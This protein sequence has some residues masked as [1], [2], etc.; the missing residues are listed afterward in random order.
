MHAMRDARNKTTASQVKLLGSECQASGIYAKRAMKITTKDNAAAC[1]CS[2]NCLAFLRPEDDRAVSILPWV[3]SRGRSHEFLWA[4]SSTQKMLLRTI[5]LRLIRQKAIEGVLTALVEV[6][7]AR[8]VQAPMPK[9]SEPNSQENHITETFKEK[10]CS[11]STQE[12]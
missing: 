11:V 9:S 10:G 12:F 1:L 7:W 8:R 4:D 6:H 5:H 3:V 2:L